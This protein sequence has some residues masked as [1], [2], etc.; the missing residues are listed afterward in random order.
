MTQLKDVLN[1]TLFTIDQPI[2]IG[3]SMYYTPKTTDFFSGHVYIKT[4]R[5]TGHGKNRVWFVNVRT[6]KQRSLYDHQEV[7][8]MR[9]RLDFLHD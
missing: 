1:G 5:R 7:N 4:N 9:L 3:D 8:P 2:V 6:G